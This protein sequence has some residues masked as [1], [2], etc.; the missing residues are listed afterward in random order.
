MVSPQTCLLFLCLVQTHVLGSCFMS[1][2]V[3]ILLYLQIQASWMC[4][5]SFALCHVFVFKYIIHCKN[6]TKTSTRREHQL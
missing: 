4:F 3:I 6:E 2:P 1:Y 5:H